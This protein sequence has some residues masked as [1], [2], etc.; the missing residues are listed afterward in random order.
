VRTYL[1]RYAAVGGLPA[2]ELAAV[3]SMYDQ[4]QHQRT[5][6]EAADGSFTAG[7]AK[8]H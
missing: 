6:A 2:A 5:D 7:P 4:L 8:H 1:S 3:G